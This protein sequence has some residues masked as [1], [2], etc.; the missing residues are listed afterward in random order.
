MERARSNRGVRLG[1]PGR[2]PP[3]SEPMNRRML[4]AA[5][6]LACAASLLAGAAAAGQNAMDRGAFAAPRVAAG[7]LHGE[8]SDGAPLKPGAVAGTARDGAVE[9]IGGAPGDAVAR[10][11][12]PWRRQADRDGARVRGAARDRR[13]ARRPGLEQ[14]P[15]RLRLPAEGAR[16]GGSA[17]RRT[18]RGRE[19]GRG[20]EDGS[21][22]EP[23][24]GRD[25]QSGLRPDR[26]RSWARPRSRVSWRRAFPWARSPRAAASAASA[27]CRSRGAGACGFMEPTARRSLGTRRGTCS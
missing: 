21:R 3:A 17:R 12:L 16:P 25:G 23:H 10:A 1:Q 22:L 24:S 27:G 15:L 7:P 4:D 19:P 18:R 8:V 26:G 6:S 9:C 20:S 11:F 14:R 13:P 2:A 5:P